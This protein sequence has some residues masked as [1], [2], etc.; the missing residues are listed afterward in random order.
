MEAFVHPLISL[1]TRNYDYKK[2][3]QIINY[4]SVL[5]NKTF[6]LMEFGIIL[7]EDFYELQ[8]PLD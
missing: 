7:C 4:L 5:P 3:K 6:N 1:V 8:G 2:L